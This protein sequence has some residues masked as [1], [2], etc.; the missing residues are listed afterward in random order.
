MKRK[1]ATIILML[2]LAFDAAAQLP[3]GL[4]KK[5]PAGPS[6]AVK[7]KNLGCTTSA[8]SDTFEISSYSFGAEQTSSGSSSGGAG[9]KPTLSALNLTKG[10]GECSPRLF[11][12][13]VTGNHFPSADLLQ[14]DGDG[15]TVLTIN[16]TDAII[17]SYEIA[18]SESVDRPNESISIQFEKICIT[19]A[20]STDK[21]CYDV[22]RGTTF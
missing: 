2:S 10:F 11:G 1:I 18:G 4:A 14:Q 12:A 22:A 20:N 7:I 19:G 21:L 6:I 5:R 17:S 8:G 16:L 15:N 9:G 13:V 3:P